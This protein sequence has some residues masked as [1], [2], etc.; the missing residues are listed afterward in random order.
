[1][2]L[3]ELIPSIAHNSKVPGKVQAN[4][5]FGSLHIQ[6]LGRRADY[7]ISLTNYMTYSSDDDESYP[8]YKYIYI[9]IYIYSVCV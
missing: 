4:P 8:T 6:L 5:Y 7:V 1:L 3:L 9:Y 2:L